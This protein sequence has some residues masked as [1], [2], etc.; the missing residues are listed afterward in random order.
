MKPTRSHPCCGFAERHAAVILTVA[1]GLFVTAAV[2]SQLRSMEEHSL[3]EE[4]SNQAKE[5]ANAWLIAIEDRL[6]AFGSVYGLY[7]SS[8]QVTRDEF[9][10]FAE[11]SVMRYRGVKAV[12]WV[13]R[14]SPQA[15]YDHEQQARHEGIEKY[16]IV[17]SAG[18]STREA[19]PI[20]Y[21][22][23]CYCEPLAEN[24]HLLGV[25][26]ASEPSWQK[27]LDHAAETDQM[28]VTTGVCAPQGDKSLGIFYAI[29]PVYRRDN[30]T[31]TAVERHENLE[32]FLIGVFDIGRSV[33]PS[34]TSLTPRGIDIELVKRTAQGP[35]RL[36]S[37]ATRRKSPGRSDA[38]RGPGHAPWTWEMPLD[39]NEEHWAIRCTGAGA[40]F[41]G[42]QSAA[43]FASLIVGLVGTCVAAYLV[44]S[45]QTRYRT[46]E[47]LVLERTQALDASKTQLKRRNE[48]LHHILA[49]LTHP[50]YVIDANDFTIRLSNQSLDTPDFHTPPACYRVIHGRNTP[51]NSGDCLHEC[52]VAKVKSTRKPCRVERTHVDREG[53]STFC[54]IYAY[55]VFDADGNVSEVIEYHLDVTE[56]K[57][58]QKALAESE[59]KFRTVVET[60]KDAM[61]VIDKD[62]LISLFNPAAEQMFGQ[63]C[64]AML[65]KPLDSII[66]EDVRPHHPEHVA[67]YFRTGKPDNAIGETTELYAQRRDGTTFPTELSLSAGRCGDEPFVLGIMRDVTER[68]QL[69]E[70]LRMQKDLLTHILNNIP[71]FVFWKDRNCTYL[72]CNENFARSAGVGRPED[73]AGKTDYDL[74]WRND[75]EAYQQD[76]KRVIDGGEPLLAF[77]ET[78][79][80]AEGGQITLLTSKVPLKGPLRYSGG[81]S[82]SLHGHHRT[83]AHS[84]GDRHPG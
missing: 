52:S 19:T 29:R 70:Q 82:R 14:V 48:F 41:A 38:K 8:E 4:F 68:K 3:K 63:S 53:R 74:V 67:S 66:P 56:R 58:T 78:Q 77:E 46:V 15:R 34:L 31:L 39:F 57:E 79:T 62:G 9:H 40:F 44:Y 13:P 81:D 69:E 32:G 23:I 80:T 36:Y 83:Q 25:D 27:A 65:G 10:L 21:F 42:R 37:H 2:F 12:Q 71:T 59:Q 18:D 33:E 20:A 30:L 60:S 22:P 51:C 47:H 75:A 17:E 55:P 11:Q 1:A 45:Y 35:Q 49:S 26:L 5:R 72:G 64:T 16:R 24:L 84:G 61:V 7:L 28:I 54:E 43:S 76:D 73:I 50:L 6:A